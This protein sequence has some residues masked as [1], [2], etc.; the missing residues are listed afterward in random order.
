MKTYLNK[1]GNIQ[2]NPTAITFE[3]TD[4]LL[5][6]SFLLVKEIP[7]SKIDHIISLSKQ[8]TYSSVRFH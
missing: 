2:I 8:K 7:I 3:L 6:L 4:M 1:N 5:V